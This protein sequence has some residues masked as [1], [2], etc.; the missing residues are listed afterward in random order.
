VSKSLGGLGRS[1]ASFRSISGPAYELTLQRDSGASTSEPSSFSA[2]GEV[3]ETVRQR[4]MK[5][6]VE[7]GRFSYRHFVK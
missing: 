6:A 2:C 7:L 4:L 1:H 5:V 3:L